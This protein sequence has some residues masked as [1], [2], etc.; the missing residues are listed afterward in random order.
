MTLRHVGI[1]D[2][3][4]ALGM[5]LVVVDGGGGEQVLVRRVGGREVDGVEAVGDEVTM[6][7]MGHGGTRD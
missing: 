5:T 7:L 2:G 6:G 4:V 3:R 1:G